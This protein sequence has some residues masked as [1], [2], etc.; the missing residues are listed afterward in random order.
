MFG[1]TKASKNPIGGKI[2]MGS[3]KGIVSA[4][5]VNAPKKTSRK[6]GK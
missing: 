6:M 1:S 4:P 3:P 2:G 5:E